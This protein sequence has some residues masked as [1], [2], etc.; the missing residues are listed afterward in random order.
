MS[1][2]KRLWERYLGMIKCLKEG[3]SNENLQVRYRRRWDRRRQS[4]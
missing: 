1:Y 2:M 3:V 4:V